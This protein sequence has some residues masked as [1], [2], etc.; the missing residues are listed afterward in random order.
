MTSDDHGDPGAP[1][2]LDVCQSSGPVKAT[3]AG[4]AVGPLDSTRAGRS[5]QH[6]MVNR[7]ARGKERGGTKKDR[8][9]STQSPLAHRTTTRQQLSP[10][11][12]RAF[13]TSIQTSPGPMAPTPPCRQGMVGRGARA[14]GA[15]AS[16]HV[17]RRAASVGQG[18]ARWQRWLRPRHARRSQIFDRGPSHAPRQ[19]DNTVGWARGRLNGRQ[20]SPGL[21][22]RGGLGGSR[23]GPERGPAR[24]A[25][26]GIWERHVETRSALGPATLPL[27][28]AGVSDPLERG[29]CPTPRRRASLRP[30]PTRMNLK[31]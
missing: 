12:R 16:A 20:Q 1:V 8:G 25:A 27:R 24:H 5:S 2:R 11:G 29:G 30:L 28:C 18:L 13:A 15:E 4:E 23:S 7:V 14:G 6:P 22:R 31:S 26:G 21:S 9:P 17:R 3:R 10:R 19:T